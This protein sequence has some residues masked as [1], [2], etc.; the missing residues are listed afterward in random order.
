MPTAL[1][2]FLAYIALDYVFARYIKATAE[3]R[4]MPAG[5]WSAAILAFTGFVTVSYV[6]NPWMLIPAALGAFVG[7]YLSVAQDEKEHKNG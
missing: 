5:I 3:K 7:T 4:P 1:L 6:S 2:V